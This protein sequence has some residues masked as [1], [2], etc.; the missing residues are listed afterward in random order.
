MGEREGEWG[1]KEKKMKWGREGKGEKKNRR[2][3]K[4]LVGTR[5]QNRATRRQQRG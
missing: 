5:P 1:E 3:E 2:R 4:G